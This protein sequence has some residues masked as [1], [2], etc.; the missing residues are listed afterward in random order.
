MLRQPIQ[1]IIRFCLVVSCVTLSLTPFL[2]GGT[3]SYRSY[4]APEGVHYLAFGLQAP[5]QPAQQPPEVVFLID[6]SASQMGQTRLDTLEA[7]VAAINHLPAGSKIQILAMDVETEALTAQF[8]VKGSPELET[9]LRALHRRVPLGATDFGKGLQVART[10][11]DN[12][13]NNARRSVLYFGSGRSMAKAF[14]PAVFEKEAQNFVE[15]KIPFTVCAVG[16]YANLGFTAALAN[17]TGGNLIDMSSSILAEESID[18]GKE[19]EGTQRTVN[20][21][22]NKVDWK[23]IGKQ[24]ADAATATVVWVDPASVQFPEDLHIFPLQ[25]QPIRSDRATILVGATESEALPA[26]NLALTGSTVDGAVTLPFQLAAAEQKF[27]DNYLRTVVE[28]AARDGG[29]LMP[30]VGWNS[31]VYIQEMFIADIENQINKADTAIATGN[32]REAQVLLDNV[33]YADPNNKTAR[34]MFDAAENILSNVV[35]QNEEPAGGPAGAAPAS[36]YIDTAMRAQSLSS[37]KIQN[38]VRQAISEASR[39]TGARYPNFDGI[40]QNLKLTQQMIRS[41]TA[42]APA[43]R[44]SFLDR[45]GNTIRQVEHEQYAREF[46]S[47]QEE[48]NRA[49]ARVRQEN[50]RVLGENKEKTIQIFARFTALMDAEEYRAAMAVGEEA[51]LLMP[52][53]PAPYVARRMAQMISYI[54]EYE[55]LRHQRHIGFL[56]TFMDAE[57]SFIPVPPEPPITYIDRDKWKLLSDYRKEKYSTI[58]LSDPDETVKKIEAILESRDISLVIDDTT[59]FGDLFQMIK[60]ELRRLKMPDIHIELDRRALRDAN[61]IRTDS[62]L[63]DSGEKFDH[64]RMRFRS[65]LTRLLS[66]LDLTYIIRDETLLITTVEESK[67]RDNMIIKVYPIADIFM[68]EQSGGMMGGMGGMGGMM[69]GGG[70]YGGGSG[71]YGGGG[72]GNSGGWGNSGGSSWGNNSGGSNWGSSSNRNSGSSW[73]SSG[74]S[75]NRNNRSG[76]SWS[77][78]DEI[79]RSTVTQASQLLQNARSA[80]DCGEFWTNYFAQK[81][82]DH[83][84]VHDVVRRLSKEMRTDKQNA[85]QIVA[86]IEAAILSGNAQPW[87]YEALTLSLYFNEAPKAK[88]LRAALSAADFCQDPIDLL[89]VGFVMRELFDLEQQA[90]PLYQQALENMPPQRELC[91]ATLRLAQGLFEKY[92]DEESLRWIGLVAISHEWDGALGAKL[93]LDANDALAMLENRLL[94]QDRN[95]E[96]E[97][98]ALDIREAKLRDFVVTVEWTGDAG[99]DLMVSEPSHSL[100]WFK[101]PR[102]AS[103]GLLKSAPAVNPARISNQSAAKKISYVVPKGFNGNY[104]LILNKSWGTLANDLIKVTVVTNTVPGEVKPEGIALRMEPEGIV[105]DYTLETGRRTE[106]VSE[107]ELTAA[108][109]QMNAAQQVVNR[110]AL[111]Q[112]LV[113]DGVLGQAATAPVAAVVPVSNPD[114]TDYLFGSR[115]IGYAPVIE[116]VEQGVT[117]D[118]PMIAVSPDRRYVLMTINQEFQSIVAV[119]QYNP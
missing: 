99:I 55:K 56:E 26:F 88:V 106:S 38:E 46:R 33:L 8:A 54:D 18:W 44:D 27:G 11:F 65:A 76:N 81:N 79:T 89:N 40:V 97:Q 109:P 5:E 3:V 111:L 31:M 78:P 60:D 59:T 32:P 107:A 96:A 30:I 50:A 73:G 68:L 77:V 84:L 2:N 57:R 100:C 9:A 13:S 69:G 49:Q 48:T 7:V 47:V 6:T 12:A 10:V 67:K 64:P 86:L 41:N 74:S 108:A 39:Q 19:T 110:N 105:L 103:G 118:S 113:D 87:M 22:W 85:D 75:N 94:K 66:P 16:S 72:F 52:D 34:N 1:K 23:K 91:A 93:A 101:N 114:I 102:S 25:M 14:S 35:A 42:L 36:A 61:E 51:T 82:V 104:S 24:I 21:D 98:L 115:Y 15:Q 116:I 112:R 117:F 37:Q 28:L 80:D 92:N 119:P 70:M 29:A 62:P 43:E 90:F 63:L 53:D 4:T 58:A 83:A 71:M 45:L 20:V 95:E 17:R